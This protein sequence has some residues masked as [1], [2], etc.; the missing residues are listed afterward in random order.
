ALRP[1]PDP[2]A[3]PAEAAREDLFATLVE[4]CLPALRNYARTLC[5]DPHMADDCV[6]DACMRALAAFPA[7]DAA[8]P[9]RPWIFR[10]LRN[11]WLQRLRRERRMTA[12]PDEDIHAML[13]DQRTP[14]DAAV[15]ADLLALIARLPTGM[16][17]AVNLVLGLGLSYEEAAEACNCAPGTMKSRVNRARALLIDQIEGRAA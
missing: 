13:V 17:D 15:G 1:S 12:M 2:A 5:G 3:A 8:R 16:A 4:D 10:I 11:E 6:Q 9:F 14:E 7:Y